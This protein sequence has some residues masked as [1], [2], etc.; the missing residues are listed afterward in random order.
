MDPYE[1]NDM[2]KKLREGERVMCPLCKSG[3]LEP[4]GACETTH[5]FVCDNCKKKLNI[6]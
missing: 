6:N 3:V 1:F 4:V 2:M 5:C